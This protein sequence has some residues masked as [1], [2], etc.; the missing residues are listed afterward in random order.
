MNE[1]KTN[2]R[3]PSGFTNHREAGRQLL[4]QVGTAPSFLLLGMDDAS[5][6]AHAWI[7]DSVAGR[8]L[9]IWHSLRCRSL[10]TEG[11]PR[12]DRARYVDHRSI[13]AGPA[14]P[15]AG[16]LVAE[17]RRLQNFLTPLPKGS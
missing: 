3:S 1:T 6:A 16:S 11:R 7:A 12:A 2:T 5:K 17:D 10:A 9:G 13:R 4:G 14:D 15:L 8:L